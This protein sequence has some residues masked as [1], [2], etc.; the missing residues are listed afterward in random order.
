MKFLNADDKNWIL[1]KTIQ[2]VVAVC[3]SV[4][5]CSRSGFAPTASDR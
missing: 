1:S 5:G 3:L 2:Q 4:V